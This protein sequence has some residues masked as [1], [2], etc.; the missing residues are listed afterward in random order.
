MILC[1][2][3]TTKEFKKNCV[4]TEGSMLC[5]QTDPHEI[6]MI[7]FKYVIEFKKYCV[8]GAVQRYYY[9]HSTKMTSGRVV[10]CSAVSGTVLHS[11]AF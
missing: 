5:C 7:V 1:E 8:D 10:L 6:I 2:A 11:Q 3:Q 9:K 4:C